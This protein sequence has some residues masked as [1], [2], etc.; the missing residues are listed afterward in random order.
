MLHELVYYSRRLALREGGPMGTARRYLRRHGPVPV[1]LHLMAIVIALLAVYT[2]VSLRRERTKLE[3][4][5]QHISSGLIGLSQY[6]IVLKYKVEALEEEVDRKREQVQ[7]LD[8]QLGLRTLKA[9]NCEWLN[10]ALY[11]RDSEQRATIYEFR[12]KWRACVD[13]PQ[14]I[15]TVRGP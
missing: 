12:T 9:E 6:E 11:N 8:H 15:R 13:D 3:K 4:F 5:N 2:Q 1:V 14:R 7:Q 10:E